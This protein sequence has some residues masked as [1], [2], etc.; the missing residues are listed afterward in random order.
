ERAWL[1]HGGKEI[2]AT[3]MQHIDAVDR[4]DLLDIGETFAGLD[5]AHHQRRDIERGDTFGERHRLEIEHW[6]AGGDRAFGDRRELAGLARGLGVGGVVD[7]GED[8][9]G[10]AVVEDQRGVGMAAAPTRTSGATPQPSAAWA[11][12]P[13]VSSENSECCM[14]M[15]MKSWQLL[16]AMR[17]MSPE[18]A[19]RTIMPSATSPAR[20][21]SIAGFLSSTGISF[22]TAVPAEARTHNP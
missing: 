14:S 4:R 9:A 5:H 2:V 16:L 8:D 17:A 13:T 20:M 19:S 12:W 6:V 21:R 22:S 1:A 15:K 18:R 7:V 3:D 11:M 10:R